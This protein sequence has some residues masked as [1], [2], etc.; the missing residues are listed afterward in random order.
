MT[1]L[2]GTTTGAFSVDGGQAQAIGGTRINHLARFG[3]SWWA[4]D[5][6]G[7]VYEDGDVVATMPDG[8]AALCVQP[9]Y[10]STWIGSN[11]ARLFAFDEDGLTEDEF[12]ADAP[13]REKWYTPWGAPADVRSMTLDADHTLYINVHVGG[14]LRYDNTGLAST[15]D[16]SADVH[17]VAAHPRQKGAVFAACARGLAFSHNGHDF[18]IRSDGLHAPY[19]RAVE[20][21]ENRVLITASTGPRTDRGRVYGGDLWNGELTPVTEG[22]PEW[23]ENNVNTHCLRAEGSTV[24]LG[25]GDTVWRSDDSG[26]TWGVLTSGLPRITCLA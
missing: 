25:F 18:E 9:S 15:I 26:E 2:V 16:I 3:E 20:V 12:F 22:L 4:V 11:E 1:L 5:E 21:M 23:F 10:D 24:H 8:A 7:R 19:C 6:Q 17:Q 13:G 14:I